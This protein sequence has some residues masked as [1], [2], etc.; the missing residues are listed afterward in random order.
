MLALI[1]SFCWHDNDA[2]FVIFSVAGE[3]PCGLAVL[4]LLRSLDFSCL[5]LKVCLFIDVETLSENS[6]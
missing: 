1:S 5:I 4:V 6:D 3:S 2:I